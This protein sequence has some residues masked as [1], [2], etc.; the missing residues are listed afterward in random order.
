MLN[1]RS[2][3][4]RNLNSTR[5]F[6]FDNYYAI[7]TLYKIN[8]VHELPALSHIVVFEID[9]HVQS[10]HER[11][12]TL[13]EEQGIK[14]LETLRTSATVFQINLLRGTQTDESTRR[15]WVRTM[16]RYNTPILNF[17]WILLTRL[18]SIGFLPV[19]GKILLH[20]RVRPLFFNKSSLLWSNTYVQ[21]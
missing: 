19:T 7:G 20:F 6:H 16:K 5:R 9:N 15:N 12:N 13:L 8:T 11:I 1:E 14:H 17:G 3:L 2:S 18:N 4:V 21:Y 10:E